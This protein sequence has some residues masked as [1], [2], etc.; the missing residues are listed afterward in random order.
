MALQRLRPEYREVV[1]LHY[2]EGLTN[3]EIAEILALP[4]GTVK[5]HLHRARKELASMLTGAGWGPSATRFETPS[6]RGS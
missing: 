3:V 5:T 1:A 2:Q 6:E 4:T